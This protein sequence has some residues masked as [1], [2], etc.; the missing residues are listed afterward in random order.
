MVRN[1]AVIFFI[2][3]CISVMS[4]PCMCPSARIFII[5]FL[6]NQ[7]YNQLFEKIK[8]LSLSSQICPLQYCVPVCVTNVYSIKNLKLPMF[9][10]F[11]VVNFSL[12]TLVLEHVV[13]LI[14][15]L[16]D[17]RCC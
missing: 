14:A 4:S 9:L 2:N 7:S 3:T 15:N 16:P 10:I 1:R 13:Y 17:G 12:L 11:S 5:A 8:H 6:R